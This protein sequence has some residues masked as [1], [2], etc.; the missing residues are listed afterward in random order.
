M[1]EYPYTP[2]ILAFLSAT[3]L[4]DNFRNGS[5]VVDNT[6]DYQSKDD[7]INPQFR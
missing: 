1:K 3:G 7:M 4:T 2:S 6:P 5:S